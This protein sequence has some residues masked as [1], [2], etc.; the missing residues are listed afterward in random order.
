[1]PHPNSCGARK[2]GSTFAPGRFSSVSDW[3]RIRNCIHPCEHSLVPNP[4]DPERE[5]VFVDD[6]LA[7][8]K[9]AMDRLIERL[10]CV[11]RMLASRNAKL[12]APLSHDELRDATQDTFVAILRGLGNYQPTAPLESWIYGICCRQML[13]AIRAK[14]RHASRSQELQ[15]TDIEHT[16]K[17]IDDVAEAQRLLAQLGGLESKI[18]ELK[19]IEGLTFEELATRLDISPNTAKTSYYRGLRRL[20][21]ILQPGEEQAP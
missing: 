15:E 20:R 4:F 14:Q 8:K 19:H 10:G 2:T 17:S 5:R 12:G 9:S 13:A 11:P 6:A 21:S 3:S 18:V 1:M 16:P 7:G